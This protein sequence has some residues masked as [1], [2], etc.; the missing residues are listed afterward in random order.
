MKTWIWKLAR[1]LGFNVD[2]GVPML[3]WEDPTESGVGPNGMILL[4]PGRALTVAGGLDKLPSFVK[5]GPAGPNPFLGATL[6]TEEHNENIPATGLAPPIG[7]TT[8]KLWVEDGGPSFLL[9]ENG[10]ET[11]VVYITH[12]TELEADGHKTRPAVTAAVR[13]RGAGV[14]TCDQAVKAAWVA[15][16]R[17]VPDDKLC[18]DASTGAMYKLPRR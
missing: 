11:P 7:H 10:N 14:E 12:L 13:A 15:G 9:T 16:M 4:A 6:P 3:N 17:A 1:S 8:F 18:Y 5:E 2:T